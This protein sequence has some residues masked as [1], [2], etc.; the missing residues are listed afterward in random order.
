MPIAGYKDFA[1]CV[2]KARA[3]GI[4]KPRAYCGAIYNKIER[5][6]KKRRSTTRKK[7]KHGSH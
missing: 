4:K 5:P 2:R 7:V 3:K 6:K 1:D